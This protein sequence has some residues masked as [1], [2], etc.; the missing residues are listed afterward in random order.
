VFELT[1]VPEI[2]KEA[3]KYIFDHLEN[4]TFKPS[5]AKTFPLDRISEAHRH[6]ILMLISGQR[7]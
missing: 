7:L 3:A 5:I 4:G 2:R 6:I 1:A